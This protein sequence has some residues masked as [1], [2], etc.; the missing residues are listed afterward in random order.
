MRCHHIC[1]VILDWYNKLKKRKVTCPTLPRPSSS[2]RGWIILLRVVY[3]RQNYTY[4]LFKANSNWIKIERRLFLIVNSPNIIMSCRARCPSE[5]EIAWF[6]RPDR[7]ERPISYIQFTFQTARIVI[8]IHF[9]FRTRAVPTATS[10][11]VTNIK[12]ISSSRSNNPRSP[13]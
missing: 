3:T 5:S 6:A 1:D 10:H 7:N 9:I 4:T 12:T 8:I 13:Q 11:D 2:R